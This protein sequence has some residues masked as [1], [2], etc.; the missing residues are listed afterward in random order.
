[1][2]VLAVALLAA[3]PAA[4]AAPAAPSSGAPGV[5]LLDALFGSL[6]L[7]HPVASPSTLLPAGV[8]GR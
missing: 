1:M 2:S 7:G 3:A 4:Q 5:P 8:T 6:E